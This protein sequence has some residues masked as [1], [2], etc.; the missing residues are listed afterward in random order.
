MDKSFEQQVFD[1]VILALRPLGV[2]IYPELPMKEVPYP[3]V[4]IGEVQI[5]PKATSSTL[6]G[7]VYVTVDVWAERK[8]RQKVSTITTIIYRYASEILL[9]GKKLRL[10]TNGCNSR[11]LSD[12]STKSTLWHGIVQLEFDITI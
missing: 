6:L 9:N 5:V 11:I 1:G 7:K 3:F 4:V 2:P 12:T 10:A 8:Q